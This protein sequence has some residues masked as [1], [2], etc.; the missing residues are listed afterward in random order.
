ASFIAPR[1]DLLALMFQRE[2]ATVPLMQGWR[3]AVAGE[4]LLKQLG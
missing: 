4:A 1:A 3:R 2:Q